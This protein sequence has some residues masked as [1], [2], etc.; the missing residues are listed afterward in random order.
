MGV[1][2]TVTKPGNGQLPKKGQKITVHC[3]GKLGATGAFRL[4]CLSSLTRRY[5]LGAKFWSTKDPGQTPFSFNVGIG[6]VIRGALQRS[7]F[8][9]CLVHR[10]RR[11]GRGLQQ[12]VSGRARHPH[13]HW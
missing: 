12:H 2:K 9:P 13:L 1:E 11:M 6:Q 8:L 10:V 5:A 3:T 7:R 4:R